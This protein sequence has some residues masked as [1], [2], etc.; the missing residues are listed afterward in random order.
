MVLSLCKSH[1]GAY[2]A[3]ERSR[4]D[5]AEL[6]PSDGIVT[7]H[8]LDAVVE[9][10]HAEGPGDG[11]ALEEDEEQQA[12]AGHGVR[13][14]DLEDV[15]AALRDA[16]DADQ[17]RDDADDRDEDLLAPAEQVGPLVHH[18]RD[19]AFHGAELA[20]QPDEQQHDEEQAR[21]ERRAGQLQ[22]GGRV[23]EEG[24]PRSRGR[25]LGHR[26]LLL[27][28]HEAHHREDDE[29]REDGRRR[30]DGAHDQGVPG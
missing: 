18:G 26:F 15:H 16:R 1:G 23:G 13:V 19:E 21:P 30:V 27:V 9:A 28:R 3:D 22:H 8:V 7:D 24:Q 14:E 2:E 25:H 10:A 4:D 29:A 6:P 5:P 11:N 20:V 12:E 17:V